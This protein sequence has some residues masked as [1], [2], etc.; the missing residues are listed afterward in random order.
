MK[1]MAENAMHQSLSWSEETASTRSQVTAATKT[2]TTT[3]M[4]SCRT[5]KTREEAAAHG[6]SAVLRPSGS[7]LLCFRWRA[8]GLIIFCSWIE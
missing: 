2:T 1:M 7:G 6:A 5:I 8:E 3:A 4:S